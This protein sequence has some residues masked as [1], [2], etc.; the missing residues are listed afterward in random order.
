MTDMLTKP[1]GTGHASY[2]VRRRCYSNRRLNGMGFVPP[3]PAPCSNSPV[4][5]LGKAQ[6]AQYEEYLVPINA[7]A[8]RGG[9]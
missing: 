4:E 9:H 6:R 5:H 3:S 1:P 2:L 8:Q 7:E